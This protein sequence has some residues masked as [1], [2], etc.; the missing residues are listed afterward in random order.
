LLGVISGGRV[1]GRFGSGLEGGA[2]S[3]ISNNKSLCAA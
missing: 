3:D 1:E 2:Q